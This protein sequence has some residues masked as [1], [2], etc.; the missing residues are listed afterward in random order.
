MAYKAIWSLCVNWN[1][2]KTSASHKLS[3]IVYMAFLFLSMLFPQTMCLPRSSSGGCV[4]LGPPCCLCWCRHVGS[5]GAGHWAAEICGA[6]H[7]SDVQL[8]VLG[9][10]FQ[11]FMYIH[12]IVIYII[13]LYRLYIYLYKY[14][15]LVV[16]SPWVGCRGAEHSELCGSKLFIRSASRHVKALL[17]KSCR[18]LLGGQDWKMGE[19]MTL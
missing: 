2:W 18:V 3:H 6:S 7:S 12:N 5:I 13:Y 1:S 19:L 15:Y 16:F 10:V 14:L 8:L 4:P 11:W 9:F 17:P